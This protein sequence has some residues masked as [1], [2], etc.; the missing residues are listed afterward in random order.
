VETKLT[1]FILC[2]ITATF[3]F[4]VSITQYLMHR[5]K[6]SY[7]IQAMSFKVAGASRI[8][9]LGRR[10]QHFLDAK[11]SIEPKCLDIEVLTAFK[12]RDPS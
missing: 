11:V 3:H 4:S 8:I 9:L 6:V 5:C 12:Q 10:G 7:V 2:Y 1:A